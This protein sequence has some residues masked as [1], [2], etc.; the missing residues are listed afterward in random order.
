MV[1]LITSVGFLS[2]GI[3]ILY[4]SSGLISCVGVGFSSGV[5]SLVGVW[6]GWSLV[7]G[8]VVFRI[9]FGSFK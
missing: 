1:S 6:F 8:L 5:V 4:F 3:L 7:F 2:G 9:N